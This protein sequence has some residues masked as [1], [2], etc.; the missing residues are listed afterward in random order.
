VNG[1]NLSDFEAFGI[2]GGQ[3]HDLG[4]EMCDEFTT[5]MKYL[6]TEEEPID[7]E[8][9]F[10]QA[11]G[12]VINPKPTSKPRPILMNAGN[13]EVGLDFACRQTDWVF[14]TAADLESYKERIELVHRKAAQYGRKVRTATMAYTIMDAT[15]AMA[16]RT[17]DWVI[18]QVDRKAMQTHMRVVRTGSIIQEFKMEEV[19][20]LSEDPYFGM[21][22]ERFVRWIMGLTAWHFIGSYE[23]IASFTAWGWKVSCCASSTRYAACTRWKTTSSRSSRRWG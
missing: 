22:R 9:R 17:A 21:G 12:A 5:L 2:V 11:Y 1:L 15:D 23:T 3:P 18:E 19:D 20:K 4:Y 13:S 8:G 10:Y 16:R 14:I 6:W 7:F